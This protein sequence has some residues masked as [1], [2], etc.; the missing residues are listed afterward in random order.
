MQKND[1]IDLSLSAFTLIEMLVA[2]G[3]LIIALGIATTVFG[4]TSKV[5]R[6]TA[7]LN[8]TNSILDSFLRE[9]DEDLN[10]V[11]T[12]RSILVL[13]GRTQAA[14]L[15]E[16]QR[17][18]SRYYHVLV[19]DPNVQNL[20]MY[21]P[22]NPGDP[23]AD[24]FNGG[25]AGNYSNPRADLMMFFTQ[26][27]DAS[28]APAT[29]VTDP[30]SFQAALVRGA[31][32][33]PLRVM[34]G[35]ATLAAAA[36]TPGNW[37]LSRYRHI[38]DVT[39]GGNPDQFKMSLI[40]ANKWQLVR[41]AAII[42]PIQ[43]VNDADLF[44]SPDTF[45]RLFTCTAGTENRSSPNYSG[46][47]AGDCA[48]LALNEYLRLLQPFYNQQN[49]RV[50]IALARPYEFQNL[51]QN[52]WKPGVT[53]IPV[54]GAGWADKPPA[55]PGANAGTQRF[56]DLVNKVMYANADLDG[57][58]KLESVNHSFAVAVEDPPV[59]LANNLGMQRL[60][61]CVWF[62]VEFLM[63]EDPRN[64]P[65]GAALLPA[66]KPNGLAWDPTKTYQ[67][68]DAVRWVQVPNGSTYVFVPDSAENRQVIAS[69]D[70]AD[71][72][73]FAL[74]PPV[75]TDDFGLTLNQ[76]GNA[77]Q[78]VRTWPYAVRVTIRAYDPRAQLDQ[79]IIRTLVHRFP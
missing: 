23:N 60:S 76:S 26:R 58:G 15:T 17:L 24:V 25:S 54:V 31:K 66:I 6:Q 30:N 70:V 29:N 28:H 4:I 65:E 8:E 16:E 72:T 21:N 49:H 9:I 46:P 69:A 20:S 43:Y 1:R 44:F 67:R 7:A 55:V 12:T 35:H 64:S 53:L 77:R 47:R 3:V 71:A 61:G 45:K 57:D 41:Q 52:S 37:V 42:E 50:G 48:P 74:L 22:A 5:T 79:P 39:G 27:P 32:A 40:P 33:A 78:I 75:R 19:G 51:D 34:Y 56:M 14:A 36:G 18:A 68:D 73:G 13:Q 63:P 59:G 11:D 2:L 62:Q 38:E 10:G